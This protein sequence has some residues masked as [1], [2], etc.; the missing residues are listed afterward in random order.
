MADIITPLI[1]EV[2]D[3]VCTQLAADGKPV[4]EC[5]QTVGIP[6]MTHCEC[7]CQTG[8]GWAWVGFQSAAWQQ[9]NLSRCPTGAWNADFTAGVYRCITDHEGDCAAATADAVAVAEDVAS[10]TKA[11]LCCPVFEHRNWELGNV[12]II[13]PEGGCVGVTVS[14]TVQFLSFSSQ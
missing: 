2:L 3:C 10:I 1:T 11:L 7:D 6:P 8:Q 5:C 14:F 9:E 4:C 13:G 12:S